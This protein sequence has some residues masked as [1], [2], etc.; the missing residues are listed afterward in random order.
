MKKLSF[1]LIVAM[2]LIG[3]A[4]TKSE[5]TSTEAATRAASNQNKFEIAKVINESDI[6]PA[7]MEF[8]M[9]HFPQTGIFHCYQTQHYYKVKLDDRTHLE[10][11]HSFEWVKVDCEHSTI[12]T[13]VPTSIV[14][15][16]ITAYVTTNFPGK[17]IEEIEKKSFGWEI[18]MKNGPEIKF[19]TNFNVING[20]GNGGGNNSNFPE[21]NTFV[22]TYFPQVSIQRVQLDG[23]EIDVKLTDGTDIDFYLNFIWQSIDCEH[24]TVYGSVPSELV[25]E[26]ITD[27]VTANFPNNHIDQIEKKNNGNW[28]IELN[29]DYEIVFDANFNVIG[30]GGGNG[31]GNTSNYPE[32]N[33]FVDT[34][35]PQTSI[36]KVERDGN[37][38]EVELTDNTDINFNL[39]FEWTK[40]DCDESN[41]YGSVPT[42]LVPVQI[43]DYVTANFPNNHI[44]QI[45]KKY[46]GWDVELNNDHEIKFDSNFN[47]ISG[48]GNGGGGNGGGNNSN[49]PEINTFVDTYFPQ[50]SIRKVERDGNKYEVEL[51]DNTDIDFNLSFEWKKI[52][53]DDSNVYGSVPTELVPVQI[54]DY[55]TANFP[56]KHIDSIEKKY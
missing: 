15:E 16:Q 14:P 7:I 26:Q 37:K 45:E 12:Y 49:Y 24:A 34:Y 32:I 13:S 31:G 8:V 39:S 46:Y 2:A 36:L 23:N 41:V 53:C 29:N 5:A 11:T 3:T 18:E 54:T 44:D 19:D 35:F 56:G 43:T 30:G 55:V 40:I 21:I 48:G 20:G 4:C 27:Y 17:A 51:T 22:S 6:D 50:V 9:T 33:T 38:Y 28:E 52:D 10:F 42:E 1:I 47:V 25:P